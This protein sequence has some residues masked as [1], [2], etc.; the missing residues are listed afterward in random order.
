MDPGHQRAVNTESLCLAS[1]IYHHIFT[2]TYE[3]G[4]NV[5]FFFQLLGCLE[6]LV[7][8]LFLL[9]IGVKVIR[10]SVHLDKMG[11]SL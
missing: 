6:E 2:I 4:T 7:F 8:W 9:V 1:N 10:T 5:L 3:N 11:K